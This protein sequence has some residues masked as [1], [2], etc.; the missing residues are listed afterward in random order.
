MSQFPTFSGVVDTRS[1]RKIQPQRDV[2][3]GMK[4]NAKCGQQIPGHALARPTPFFFISDL[5]LLL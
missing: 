4:N 1:L 5:C 2:G 3:R